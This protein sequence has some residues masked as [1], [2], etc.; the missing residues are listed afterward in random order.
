MK[1]RGAQ[2][3][4]AS[5]VTCSKQVLN[6][7][8]GTAIVTGASRG[9]GKAIA[10][11]LAKE[12]YAIA[13]NCIENKSQLDKTAASLCDTFGAEVRTYQSD[14]SDLS[15][16]EGM[17]NDVL[18]WSDTIDVLINNAGIAHYGLLSDL[19]PTEWEK[20]IA[21]NLTS[22]YHTAKCVIPTMVRQQSGHILQ[23]SSIWGEYGASCEVAYSASKG[24]VNAFTKALAKE[25]AP[26]HIAV[27]AI[28]CGVIDTDMNAHLNHE[29]KEALRQ[30]IPADRFGTP[31]DVAQT[32]LGLLK[33]KY[34]TGQIIGCDGGF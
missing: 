24:G 29:E 19:A 31:E 9:I 23:I 10:E 3:L 33:M 2:T 30:E 21:T 34:V 15:A 12:G 11:A 22:C 5:P 27:N 16:V 8:R 6:G 17:I 20:I 32:V 13:I 28:S 26:S 4:T 1:K 18:T 7:N 14:V 25:L